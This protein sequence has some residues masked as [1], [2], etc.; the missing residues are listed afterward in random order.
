MA[1]RS[2]LLVAREVTEQWLEEYNAIRPYESL[3]GMTPTNMHLLPFKS[4]SLSTSEW[5]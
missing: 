4:R 1:R 2:T 5:S 3:G